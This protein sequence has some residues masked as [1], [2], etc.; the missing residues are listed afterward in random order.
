M[1][2]LSFLFF[3]MLAACGF[4]PMYGSYSG[5]NVPEGLGQVE[6]ALIPDQPG[7]YLRNLLIDRFYQNGYPDQPSYVLKVGKIEE[8]ENE[9]DVTRESE[10]TR[11]QIRLKTTMT[12]SDA[13][14]KELFSRNLLAITSYNVLGS[15]FTTRVSESDAREAALGD[16]ARQIETQVALYL[17]SPPDY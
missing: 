16:L 9:L 14:G 12:F 7:V 15:Q 5:G 6:I 13:G 2:F 8:T 11:E 3:L 17:K 1:K 4:S 10:T